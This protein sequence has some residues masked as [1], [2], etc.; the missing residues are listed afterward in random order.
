MYPEY[1]TQKK[2]KPIYALDIKNEGLE[3]LGFY[4]STDSVEII[5]DNYK[6]KKLNWIILG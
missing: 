3:N 4:A 1:I 6:Q 2:D 5:K